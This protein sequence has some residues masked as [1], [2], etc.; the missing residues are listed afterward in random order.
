MNRST[1]CRLAGQGVEFVDAP[2]TGAIVGADPTVA[3][4]AQGMVKVYA[5]V[6]STHVIIDVVGFVF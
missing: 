4:D 2:V 1:A 5:G 6:N 3:V